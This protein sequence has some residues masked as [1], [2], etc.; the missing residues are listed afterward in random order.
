MHALLNVAVQAAQKGGHTL[1]RSLNK[2]E[3]LKVD[4]KGRNDFVSDADRMQRFE[5][6]AKTLA[7][8]DVSAKL[9]AVVPDDAGFG[10]F[11][12]PEAD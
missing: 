4:V 3:R 11:L 8:S 2:L 12:A 9:Q 7:T 5:Q 6:E 10:D 1:I